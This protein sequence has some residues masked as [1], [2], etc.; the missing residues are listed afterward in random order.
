[1]VNSLFRVTKADIDASMNIFACKR[2]RLLQFVFVAIIACHTRFSVATHPSPRQR[3][4][5]RARLDTLFQH[6]IRCFNLS[7][8]FSKR[9]ILARAP[10]KRSKL[11]VLSA[12]DGGSHTSPDLEATIS[13]KAAMPPKTKE[14]VFL[15]HGCTYMNEYLGRPLSYFGAPNFSDVFPSPEREKY[16]LDTPLSPTGIQQAS[17]LARTRPSFLDIAELSSCNNGGPPIDLVVVSPLTRALQTFEYGIYPHLKDFIQRGELEVVALPQAAERLYLISDCGRP[18][19]QLKSEFGYV[20]F[21][22]IRDNWWYNPSQIAQDITYKEWRPSNRNQRY[23]CPGEPTEAFERRM[24]AL[25][26]WIDRR[27]EP[28]ILVVCHHGVIHRMTS[29]DFDNCQYRALPMESLRQKFKG[30]KAW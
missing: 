28:R 30:G 24:T 16:Y 12:R 10:P 13:S 14:V 23:A 21:G 5:C 8:R 11:G 7:P 20:N 27:P 29:L 17:K 4:Y 9:S 22:S 3:S 19:S 15:R 25:F 6:R 1:L 18:I 2:H 26:D